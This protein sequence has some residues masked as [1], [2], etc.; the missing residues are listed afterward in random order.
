MHN[1]QHTIP[2][3]HVN[4][5]LLGARR[6]GFDIQ[7][8]LAHVGLS[9]ALLASPLARVSQD[10]YARLLARL[11]RVLRDELWGLSSTP[12]PL[13]SFTQCCRLMLGART[14]GDAL[15]LGL[16]HHRLLMHELVPRLVVHGELAHLR[17]GSRTPVDVALAQAQRTFIFFAH[18]LGSWLVARR[19]PLVALEYPAAVAAE[20][21]DAGSV[22]QAPVQ[23]TLSDTVG[24]S[25]DRRWLALPVVQ[26]EDSLA[27]FLRHAPGNLLVRYRDASS[28]TERI[29]R[30]LRAHLAGEM[31][32]QE[33]IASALAMTPQTLR[34]RLLSEGQGYRSIKEGL[35]RDAAI[36]YLAQPE[37]TLPQIAHR[38]GFSESSTFQRAFKQWTGVAPGEY[39]LAHQ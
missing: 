18:G 24:W 37:L 23:G 26:T 22:L 29:R 34:R 5:V 27:E 28:V 36:E 17:I 16:R 12:L 13:G 33:A 8:I 6:Q 10:Q 9:Q 11:R 35:R 20:L 31:P 38:L 21:R 19:L 4:R 32:S 15:T 2:T 7:P 30:Q 25:M 39:R 3:A 1:T 14:L